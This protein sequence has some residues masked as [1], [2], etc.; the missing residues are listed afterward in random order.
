MTSASRG[1]VEG[2]IIGRTVTVGESAHVEGSIYAERVHIGGYAS[3]RVE[4]TSVMIAK[5]A[6]V[7]SNV[8]NHTLTIEPGAVVKGR[9]P[10]R[11]LAHMKQ[12][13]IW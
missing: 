9:R 11:P 12:E 8:T 7:P 2:D 1:R 5:T 13:R 6:R 4:A 3:G 10:W